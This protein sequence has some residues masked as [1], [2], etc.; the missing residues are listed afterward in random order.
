[1]NDDSAPSFAARQH[2]PHI[3]PSDELDGEDYG[4]E[5]SEA[6]GEASNSTSTTSSQDSERHQKRRAGL[7]KKLQFMNHLQKSLD[8]IV[9]SYICALYYMECSF[10]RLLLRIIPHYIFITPKESTLSLPAHRPHVFAV[11]VPNLL[12]ILL[13]SLLSLPQASETTRGHLHGGV[14]IDFIGQKPPTWRLSLLLLD[15]IILGAQCLML[16]VHQEREKLRKAVNPSLQTATGAQANEAAAPDT[17]QDHDAEERGILRD[18]ANMLEN[19]DE[20]ELQ[21]LTRGEVGADD[22]MGTSYSRAAVDLV[23]VLWSGNSVLANFHV[24]YAVR[25]VG[26]DIQGAAPLSLQSLGYT[27]TLAAAIAA[28]RRARLAARRQRPR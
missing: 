25:S 2:A 15:L 4:N 24:V 18:D 21:P 22:R 27:A 28:E 5:H 9:F 17:T 14:I 16:A 26:N 10:A 23:D 7:V 13:H 20:M 1:M 12:C 8:T 6:G 19:S 3:D 11:F